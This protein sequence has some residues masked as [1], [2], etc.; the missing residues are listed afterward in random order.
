MKRLYRFISSALL[1]LLVVLPLHAAE[2]RETKRVLVLYSEEKDHP[3]HGITEQGIRSAFRSNKLFDVHLYTEYLDV[4]RF[5][6]SSHAPAFADYL[7]HKYS[8]MEIHAII[9]VY[10]YAVDFLTAE[11]HTLFPKVPIIAAEISSGYAEEL[12]RSP[13][14]RFVTGTI[15]VENITG[16]MDAALRVR[17]KT[18]RVVLVAGTA[19]NDAYSEQ[20]FRRGLRLYAGKIELIDL[21]KLSMEETL[22]RVGSLGPDTLVFYS[23][24]FRDGAGKTF[25]PREALSLVAQS[26]TVPVFSLYESYLGFGIVGGRLASF[27]EQGREA[28]VQAL[29]ILKGESPASIPFGAEQAYV[30]AYDWRE[31]KRWGI[32]EKSL[33]PDSIVKYRELSAWERYKW[34][35]TGFA[36]FCLL[37]TFLIIS[38]LT[39]L[40]RRRRTEK[41]L[42]DSESRYRTVAT[43]ATDWIYWQNQDGT[44]RYVSPSAEAVTGYT[45]G[46]FAENP[47]LIRE[48]IVPEDRDSWNEHCRE[49]F[50][51]SAFR[52]I[53]FRICRRDGRIR[54]IDHRCKLVGGLDGESLG[55]RVNNRDMTER[56]QME[57]QLEDRLHEIEELKKKLEMEN[58]YLR[59]EVELKHGHEEI[60]GKS[61]AMKGLLNKVEQVAPTLSSVL[62]LG[63]TGTG[64]DLLAQA[65]HN[66]SPRKDRALVT[67]NCASLPPSLIESE[68]FG[69]EK[70]AFTGALTRMA[71]RFEFADGSTLFLDE[72]GEMPIEM[73]GKLLQVLETGQFQRLGSSKTIKCD[74]RLIAATNQDLSRMVEEGKFRQDLYYRLNVFPIFIPPL[75]ERPEDIPPLVWAF[76]REFE[77]K[78]G[79]RIETIPKKCMEALLS[80][81]WPGNAR[82]VRNMIE[83]AM[84]LNRDTTLTVFPLSEEVLPENPVTSSRLEDVERKHILDVLK[85]TGWRITGK[86]GAAEILGMKRST[87]QSKMKKLGISRPM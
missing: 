1:F 26:A 84:I 38:L 54:W 47:A 74:V 22:S 59:E 2:P 40:R 79:K 9:A 50:Q 49:E 83:H 61:E 63:E 21:T 80:Y 18:K 60:V 17:P 10:P 32:N 67:V 30:S 29:R 35:I 4:S 65:I 31:L 39:N 14:R 51:D 58:I 27:E 8:G 11:R 76:V 78:M 36:V 44:L 45:N 7:R 85:K 13:F 64:K 68:L 20:V 71:G 42:S 87:L 75:R 46:E 72:I 33:P 6:G 25:T 19:P 56:K 24:I 81:S 69:R 55:L 5:G 77:K 52:E 34:Y 16:V 57:G 66:L 12:E 3:A 82:E 43:S 70:G 62:L 37:E 48:I 23:S 41:E 73:Q 15:L 86:K 53:L 28:A